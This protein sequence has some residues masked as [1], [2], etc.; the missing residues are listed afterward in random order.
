MELGLL[1]LRL[2]LAVIMF[3]HAT[4]KLLGWFSGPGLSKSAVLFESLGQRPGRVMVTLAA[5]AELVGGGLTVLGLAAP[6]A[7]AIVAATMLVAGLSITRVKGTVWHAAGG[8]EYP[9]VLA[10]IAAVLGFTGPGNWSLDAALSAP[11]VST[12]SG[13]AAL[14]GL[15]VVVVAVL[16]TFPPLL[17]SRLTVKPISRTPEQSNAS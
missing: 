12:A 9:I 6:L 17:R 5:I 4:Q 10:A 2:L 8:G 13:A 3:I 14:T 11:W 1:L 15:L 16:A 7:A